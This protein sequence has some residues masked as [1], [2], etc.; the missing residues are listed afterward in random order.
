MVWQGKAF[1]LRVRGGGRS[2][3]TA[4]AHRYALGVPHEN[5]PHE[6]LPHENLPHEN[7]PHENL[8][9]GHLAA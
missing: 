7:L 2:L 6:N 8:P 1:R 9:H 3:V 5:L 4:H